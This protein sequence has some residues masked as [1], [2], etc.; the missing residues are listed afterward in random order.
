MHEND[1]P[2]FDEEFDRAVTEWREQHHLREDDAVLLLIELFR[3]HQEHWDRIRHR[4]MPAFEQFRA[5]LTKLAETVKAFQTDASALLTTLRQ[6]PNSPARSGITLA[7]A[8]ISALAMLVAGYL[9][10]RAW[11]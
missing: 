3:I 1:Q 5:D 2:D 9:I 8:V 4:E 6:Q 7:T 11:G 10:G